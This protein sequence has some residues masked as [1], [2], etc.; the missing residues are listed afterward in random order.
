MLK[1]IVLIFSIILF[2][3][4]K[5]DDKYTGDPVPKISN[6]TTNQTEYMQFSDTVVI[7]LDY[8]DGDGDLGFESADSLSVEVKDIR[9]AKS[10]YYHLQPLSPL[11][12]RVAI[13]G[14]IRISLKN[15]F[16]LGAGNL[17]STKFQIRIKDRS[18]N[19]SNVLLSKSITIKK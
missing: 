14:K 16:L 4:C 7:G 9:F 17:E 15:I 3:G 18:Q 11:G 5:Y 12:S 6:I 10:D 1:I 8:Q 13:S 2:F 19:W